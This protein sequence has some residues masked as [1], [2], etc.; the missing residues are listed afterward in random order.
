MNISTQIMRGFSTEAN[1]RKQAVEQVEGSARTLASGVEGIQDTVMKVKSDMVSVTQKDATVLRKLHGTLEK[2]QYLSDKA[3]VERE[4]GALRAQ[5]K[6]R[7]ENRQGLRR[8][9]MVG[10]LKNAAS[11]EPRSLSRKS[12]SSF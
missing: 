7:M 10:M 5:L 2:G 4:L 9:T 12:V 11:S 1:S 3:V 6:R 8:P